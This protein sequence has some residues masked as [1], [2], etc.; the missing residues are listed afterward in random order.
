MTLTTTPIAANTTS[1]APLP[2]VALPQGKLLTVNAKNIPLIENALGPG[3]HFQ[4]LRVD[5]EAGVW[6]VLATF[7]LTILGTFLTAIYVLRV[8]K[9][10][11]RRVRY[12]SWD[13]AE[14]YLMSKMDQVRFLDEEHGREQGMKQFLDDKTYKPGLSSYR[15]DR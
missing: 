13:D 5:V 2:L 8:A 12:M 1:G 15:R 7:S 10:A 14:N 4:P 9:H 6:V 11:Y 3:V